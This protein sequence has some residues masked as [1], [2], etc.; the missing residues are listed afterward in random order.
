[1]TNDRSQSLAYGTASYVRRIYVQHL[2][3]RYTYDLDLG[4]SHGDAA[5]RLLILYGDNGSGKTT[6]LQIL[7]HLLHPTR[8][9]GHRSFVAQQIFRKFIAEFGDGTAVEASRMGEN[10]VGSYRMNIRLPSGTERNIDWIAQPDGAVKDTVQGDAEELEFLKQLSG[11]N[12]GLYFLSDNR[13]IFTTRHYDEF[14]EISP[15]QVPLPSDALAGGEH[16]STLRRT[17]ERLEHRSRE[18]AIEVTVYRASNWATRQVLRASTKGDEDANAIFTNI[19]KR[20]VRHHGKRQLRGRASKASLISQL[21]TLEKRSVAFSR[22]G[23]I[24]P[25]NIASLIESIHSAQPSALSTIHD[26]IKPYMNSLTARLN[27]FQRVHDSI[28]AFVGIVN[29]FFHDKSVE[30]HVG[31]GLYIRT[32]EG[33]TLA[34]GA[35]SSGERQLLLLF[36]NL[37]VASGQSSIFIVDEPELSLNVKWQRQLIRHLL[38]FTETTNVQFVFATHSIELL[39]RYKENVARLSSAPRNLLP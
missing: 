26:V 14:E 25:T 35:L 6:I 11:L 16:F 19:V 21:E 8:K 36:S 9:A 27:A 12:I 20:I 5:R 10:L 4:S 34:P 30:F 32:S 1:V 39:T 15:D 38:A 22:L 29:G 17:V 24:A 13:R 28:D 33:Q 37:L 31:R 2:F 23:L 7:F 3:G 18:A